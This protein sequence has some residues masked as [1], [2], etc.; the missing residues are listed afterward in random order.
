MANPH[1]VV[2]T[3]NFNRANA[4]TLGANWTVG[5]G[6]TS[7]GVQTNQA[8]N[9]TASADCNAFWGANA[10]G[11]DQYSQMTLAALN[12]GADFSGVSVRASG[13]DQVVF[14]VNKGT[15]TFQ[16]T[17]Y[18]AGA[19]TQIGSSFS[20]AGDPTGSVLLLEVIGTTFF[21]YQNGTQVITGSNAGVPSTGSAGVIL[22]GAT[23]NQSLWDT[24]EGGNI[25]SATAVQFITYRPPWRS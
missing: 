13:T 5:V 7:P 21:A 3:D 19:N 18:H 12:S 8:A 20:P 2:A 24:W 1:T 22:S 15:S 9:H 10:F 14:Q 6:A 4:A 17:W 16:I 11:N 23:A 25:T